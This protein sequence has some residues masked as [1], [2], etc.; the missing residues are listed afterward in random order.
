MLKKYKDQLNQ[1]YDQHPKLKDKLISVINHPLNP[2]QFEAEWASMCDEFGLH[3]RMTMQA[4]YDERHMRI[5]VLLKEFFCGTIQS[6]Q[7]ESVNTMVKGG[8][9]DNSKLV[10]EFTKHFLDDVDHIHD[11]EDKKILLMCVVFLYSCSFLDQMTEC[12]T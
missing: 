8:Y 11:N 9:L 7:S 3:D 5:A 6:K 10:H 12:L 4:L 2:E 1:I